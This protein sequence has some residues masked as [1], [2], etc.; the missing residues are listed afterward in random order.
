MKTTR[1]VSR[2]LTRGVSRPLAAVTIFLIAELVA[3]VAN[4]IPVFAA[5][6]QAPSTRAQRG[7]LGSA[8]AW[9]R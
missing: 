3:V 7:E 9:A 8:C 4:G 5:P 6:G 1:T 2:A